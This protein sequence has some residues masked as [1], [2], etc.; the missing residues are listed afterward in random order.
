MG[1]DP[2]VQC[3]T[4]AGFGVGVIGGPQHRHE[5]APEPLQERTPALLGALSQKQFVRPDPSEHAFQNAY[6]FRHVLIRETAYDGLLKRAR[7][8]LHQRFVVWADRVNGDRAM[9]YEEILGY[10][11]EQAYRYLGE[12]RSV[13]NDKGAR[14]INRAKALGDVL[15]GKAVRERQHRHPRPASTPQSPRPPLR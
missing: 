11:L 1:P 3:F 8:T 9:E 6:R 14:E 4:P 13:V 7:A 2:L 12:L 5:L 10:H 15:V